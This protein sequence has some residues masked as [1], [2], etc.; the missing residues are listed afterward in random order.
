MLR[1][2]GRYSRALWRNPRRT[3]DSRSPMATADRICMRAIKALVL[4]SITV[5]G[6]CLEFEQTVTLSADGSGS[7]R[8]RMAVREGV[9]REIQRMTPAAQL[10][11]GA[12]PTAVFDEQLV[13]KELTAAG[14]ELT[15]HESGRQAERR[16]VDLTATFADFAALQQSPLCGSAAEWSIGDGP[17]PETAKLTL[18]P[19]GRAAWIEARQ[20]ATAMQDASDPVVAEFFAKRKQQLAGLDVVVRFRLPG[21]VLVWTA[22]M[23]KTGEREVTAHLTSARI[24]TAHDLV[25]WLAPR[26]EV[27]FDAKGCTLPR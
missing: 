16:S 22:N 10:G 15:A 21:D 3:I 19:Q 24:E 20:K 26:F 1:T 13:R 23:E 14:L 5:A 6:G 4:L 8:V 17:R 25:R 27:I 2:A 18:Y 11:A 7:Q 9:L 12:N